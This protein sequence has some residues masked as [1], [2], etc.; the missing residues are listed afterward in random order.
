MLLA[1]LGACAGGD[2]APRA[3][4]DAEHEAADLELLADALA[5]APDFFTAHGVARADEVTALRSGHGYTFRRGDGALVAVIGPGPVNHRDAS[6][7]FRPI[8][9]A[10]R[11]WAGAPIVAAGRLRPGGSMARVAEPAP[12]VHAAF[13]NTSNALA[14]Y[15]PATAEQGVLVATDVANGDRHLLGR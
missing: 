11:P 5:L 13:A 8:D 4:A 7:R 15:F 14:S 9:T 10:V 2:G 12:P 6:R 1:A 3:D